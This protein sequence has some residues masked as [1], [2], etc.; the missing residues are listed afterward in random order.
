M[1]RRRFIMGLGLALWAGV[2]GAVGQGRQSG[3]DGILAA[4]G[5]SDIVVPQ[6]RGF[7]LRHQQEGVVIEEVRA[8]VSIAGQ[9]ATTTLEVDVRNPRAQRAEAVLLLPVPAGAAISGFD[10]AGAA[11]APSARLLARDEARRTY[12]A[13]VARIKDPALLEFAGHDLVRS[14]VFPVPPGGL[15]TVR[16]TYQQLLVA[17]GDR[18]DYA[19]PRSESLASTVPWRI[20][21]DLRADAPISLVFSPSHDLETLERSGRHVVLRSRGTAASTAPGPFRLSYLRERDGVTASVLAYPDEDHGGGYFLLL[22]GLPAKTGAANLH[23][24]REVTLVIDRSGSMAGEKMEQARAAALMV[25]EGLGAGEVFNIVDYADQ[26]ESFAPRPV[27]KSEAT[28]VEARRYLRALQAVGGTNL[29]EALARTLGQDHTTGTLPLVL[30]LTDGLPTVGVTSEVAIRDMVAAAN[31]SER[32][33]FSFGVGSDVNVPLLDRLAGITRAVSTYVLPGE[34][35]EVKVGSVFRKL[36]GPVL[37][38]LELETVDED[39]AVTT[40]AV[41]DL[42][43]QRI[44]DL[45]EGDQ[46]VLLGRYLGDQPVHFRLE[47]SAAWGRR[48]FSFGFDPARASTRN[49]FVPRLWATRQIA[50]LVDE[51]RQGGA[52]VAAIPRAAGNPAIRDPRREEL[53]EEILRLST[54]FGVLSEYT[55][56]LA[57]EG[58]A[59][60]DWGE[61]RTTCATNLDLRAVQTRSGLG[62]VNQGLNS[63]FAQQQVQVDYYNGFWD[64]NNERVTIGNVQ[65][66]NDRAFL[67]R[68]IRWIDSGLVGDGAEAP[69]DEV[70]D[71]GSPAHHALL[72][73]LAGEGRAGCLSLAGEI[74]LRVDGRRILVRNGESR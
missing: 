34:D 57:T 15:Q 5:V 11:A 23:M 54:R 7:G 3:G 20:E 36:A 51:I 9:A 26:V 46:L 22:A 43:P 31:T 17:D 50:F 33:I 53:V 21:V 6:V 29:H 42:L 16:V 73:R 18:I 66:I 59:L 68:G 62:A 8:H 71:F 37:A 32:R 56:F 19:L 40:R 52:E 45:F 27:A 67:Q 35:V 4:K 44:P 58:T 41:R 12:D 74:L 1:Q 24:P 38:N 39:G 28:M 10:F 2:F 64:E 30:F 72:T 60:E 14:S 70:V 47:G 25:L 48:T 63:N 69:P 13:I 55:A 49:Y 65:Q 61:L